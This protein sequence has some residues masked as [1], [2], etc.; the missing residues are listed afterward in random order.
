MRSKE[1]STN[2]RLHLAGLAKWLTRGKA[3]ITNVGKFKHQEFN[4][5]YAELAQKSGLLDIE[6]DT[7]G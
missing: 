5:K 3:P 7:V 6:V 1:S 4:L 2:F